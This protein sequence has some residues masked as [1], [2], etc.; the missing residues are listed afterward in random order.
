MAHY[1]ADGSCRI[2]AVIVLLAFLTILFMFSYRKQADYITKR[3]SAVLEKEENENGD[4]GGM[5]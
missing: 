5:R 4:V 3:I 1:F 2:V